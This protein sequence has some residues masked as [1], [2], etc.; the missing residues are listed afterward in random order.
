MIAPI[1]EHIENTATAVPLWCPAASPTAAAGAVPRKAE[2][3]PYKQ[4]T[5]MS[6]QMFGANGTAMIDTAARVP[7]RIMAG[8]RPT[9]SVKRPAGPTAMV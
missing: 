8:R 5:T 3:T 6:S 1:S 7:P 2:A 4:S 9:V